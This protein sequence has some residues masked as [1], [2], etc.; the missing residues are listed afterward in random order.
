MSAN[1]QENDRYIRDLTFKLRSA[2]DQVAKAFGNEDVLYQLIERALTKGGLR[3]LQ[4]AVGAYEAQWEELNKRLSDPW[5]PGPKI[6]Q[7]EFNLAE[8]SAK[9]LRLI[10]QI[11]GWEVGKDSLD[12]TLR[13][14]EDG[15][16]LTAG[17]HWEPKMLDIPVR[18]HILAGTSKK[19]ATLLLK[20][21]LRWL[22]EGF[23][24]L[25]SPSDA[26]LDKFI[27]E[28]DEIDTGD[29][30]ITREEKGQGL[31]ALGT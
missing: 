13:P 17:K 31:R 29:S 27:K 22:D 20:K 19:T 9:P 30:R 11:D 4:I 10:L 7:E 16:C 14:D 18:V 5:G 28:R 25:V 6:R 2:K 15:H 23:E 24:S 21:A 3:R 8:Y 12:T 1:S 26:W